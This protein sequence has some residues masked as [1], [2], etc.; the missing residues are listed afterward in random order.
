[1][2]NWENILETQNSIKTRAV[3]LSLEKLQHKLYYKVKSFGIKS[4]HL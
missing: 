2:K 4:P 3:R 1:M